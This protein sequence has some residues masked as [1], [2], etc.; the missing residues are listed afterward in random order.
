VG[1]AAQPVPVQAMVSKL[2]ADPS[3]R[4]RP[5]RPECHRRS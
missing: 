4:V 3:C 5:C 2:E 1:A